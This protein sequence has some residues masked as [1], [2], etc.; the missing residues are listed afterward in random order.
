M[1]F[2]AFPRKAEGR[3]ANRR[4]R[5]AGKAPGIVYGGGQ[6]PESIELDHNALFHALRNEKFHASILNMTVDGKVTKV[7]LRDVQM[8]PVKDTPDHVDFL[9]VSERTVITV[10][11]PVHLTG[12]EKS[13]GVKAGG[14]VNLVH[15]TLEVSLPQRTVYLDADLTRLAQVFGNLLTNSAK[16]TPPGGR[17]WV[18]AVVRSSEVAVSVRDNGIGIPAESLPNI[19]DM[20]SQVDRTFERSTGGLGI[21]LALVKGLTEMHGGKLAIQS[22]VGRGTIVTI[23]LPLRFGG[24]RATPEATAAE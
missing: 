19:F 11:V 2:T 10:E 24:Q 14:V 12:Q 18:S 17:I 8:H 4:M 21:G 15:H 22:E 16:Y 5:R 1:E 3:G 13:P 6:Q 7:L 20:F 23:T 9:R